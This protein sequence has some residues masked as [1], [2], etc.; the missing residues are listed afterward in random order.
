MDTD[1]VV[2]VTWIVNG[3]LQCTQ[4]VWTQDVLIVLKLETIRYSSE[5]VSE[6]DTFIYDILNYLLVLLQ[7]RLTSIK[8]QSTVTFLLNRLN[9]CL[10]LVGFVHHL[11]GES[12][13]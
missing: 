6:T 9:G 3:N 10:C 7:Q 12:F 2:L 5:P 11:L 1:G 13:L 8:K 4:F